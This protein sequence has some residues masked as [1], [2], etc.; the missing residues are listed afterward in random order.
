MLFFTVIL[1]TTITA[2]IILKA[3]FV[4]G[5]KSLAILSALLFFIECLIL[6]V[7]LSSLSKP[8]LKISNNDAYV[9]NAVGKVVHFL[10]GN[11]VMPVITIAS[12]I[13]LLFS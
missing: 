2:F 4:D 5:N 8:T 3:S 7:L 12:C 11:P 13:F 1:V 6:S 10:V 9:R